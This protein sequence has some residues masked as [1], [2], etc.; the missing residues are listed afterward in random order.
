MA[1]HL[2]DT[3]MREALWQL[4]KGTK[5]LF[6][7]D[8][9]FLFCELA[10]ECSGD[11]DQLNEVWLTM[12]EESIDPPRRIKTLITKAFVADGRPDPF[13]RSD[14]AKKEK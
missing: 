11:A 13:S 2:R 1:K 12:Q 4:V 9:N 10:Y 6:G 8:R 14:S 3:G 5:G 7:C